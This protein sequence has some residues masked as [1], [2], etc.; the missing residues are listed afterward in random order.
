MTV[1]TVKFYLKYPEFQRHDLKKGQ[2]DDRLYEILELAKGVLRFEISCHKRQLPELF[3]GKSRITYRDLLDEERIIELLNKYKNKLLSNLD[4]KL[5]N[6]KS[7]LDKLKGY[8][9]HKKAL[10]LY[11]FYKQFYSNS[12]HEKQLLR[13][14]Y[15]QT[16]IWRN[17]HDLASIGIGILSDIT[18]LDFSLDI[19]SSLADVLLAP[20]EAGDN[21]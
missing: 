10:R 9:P 20:A 5:V 15:H 11:T 21:T 4:P 2:N 16:T 12:P 19:P 18:S 7:V 8:Y 14:N 6:D 1:Y 3:Y 13:D 17:K